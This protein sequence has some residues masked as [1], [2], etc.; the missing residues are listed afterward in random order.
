MEIDRVNK[1]YLPLA[2]GDFTVATGV[3]ISALCGAA[4][5]GIG[6]LSGSQALLGTLGGSLALGIAYSADCPLLRWKR[7]P[8]AAA[9]CI[10]A[11]R[12]GAGCGAGPSA[13]PG[14]ARS[15]GG[16][17]VAWQA[18]SRARL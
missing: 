11:V 17:P 7:S 18:G 14:P 6:L 5:L 10:L 12:C 9:A 8:V 3:A 4:G 16:G 15:S 13:A 2:S 1:P